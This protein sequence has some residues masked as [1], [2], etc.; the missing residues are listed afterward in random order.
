MLYSIIEQLPGHVY[1]LNRDNVYLGCN[2]LQ[3]KRYGLKST[4]DVI[5]KTNKELYPPKDADI[6]E[7]NN[8]K[9]METG[10]AFEGEENSIEG[11]SYLTHKTPIYDAGGK[12]AG[13]LGIS[14]DITD[15]KRAEDLAI[16]NKIQTKFGQLAKQVCH[17]IRTPLQTLS[18]VLKVGAKNLPEKEYIA[19]RDSVNSIKKI[20][21]VFLEYSPEKESFINH[22][23]IL[24]SQTLKEIIDQKE[25]QY[26][27]K[28]VKFQYS[29]DES[30]RFTF[31]FGNAGNFE[32][33]IS[34]IVNNSVEALEEEEGVVELGFS[35]DDDRVK[36]TIKDN[37]K[38][39]PQ[40]TVEKLMRN[41]SV[42]STKEGGYGIG[43]RQIQDALKEFN[44]TQFI[45]STQNVGTKIML[46]IPKSSKSK[47]AIEQIDLRKGCVV[48]ILDDDVLVHNKWRDRLEK[49]T[50]DISLKFFEKAQETI[51]FINS[52][53]KR[54]DIILLLDYELRNQELNGLEVIQKSDIKKSQIVL[55]SS[56]YDRKEI[57][58]KAVESEIKILPKAFIEDVS[59]VFSR[60]RDDKSLLEKVN[61]VVLDNEKFFANFISDILRSNGLV[62]DTYY[63]PQSLM[64]NLSKYSVDTKI[65]TDNCFEGGVS[66]C[67]LAHQL[68]EKGFKNLCV[69]TG[70]IQENMYFKYPEGTKFIEKGDNDSEMRVFSWCKMKG[71]LNDI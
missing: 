43:T 57:Q 17:D 5:G 67:V 44:G 49:Y 52:H 41:E 61:V 47:W 10:K 60:V 29:F 66:G 53:E 21:Q 48:V 30:I 64:E 46:T 28:S 7:K 24:V 38:G 36:I 11:F 19:L 15:R 3:A 9:V 54:E 63:D 65:I 12:I 56:I 33:M 25:I 26:I 6:I 18:M 34:N 13:L 51:D 69:F 22:Q 55:V 45:E 68:F 16:Q 62:V 1:W 27:D 42:S 39:M 59:I 20:V 40:E 2:N 50:P 37:G 8:I 23:H 32:R 14:I 31:I 70:L 35:V 58:D 4:H 71:V